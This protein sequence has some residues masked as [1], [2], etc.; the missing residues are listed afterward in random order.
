MLCQM[1]YVLNIFSKQKDTFQEPYKTIN[2]KKN[3]TK[4]YQ[5]CRYT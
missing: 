2:S 5:F 4:N 3:K 1:F